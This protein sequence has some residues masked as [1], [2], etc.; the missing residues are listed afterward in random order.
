MYEGYQKIKK[1]S[2][3]MVSK[4]ARGNRKCMKGIGNIRRVLE[5]YG[6]YVRYKIR[7]RKIPA[8]RERRRL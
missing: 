5:M 1:L 4:I 8:C 3:N 2:T 7:Q 6:R